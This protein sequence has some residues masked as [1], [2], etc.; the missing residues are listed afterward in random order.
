MADIRE[1]VIEIHIAA[2]AVEENRKLTTNDY[3]A[4]SKA[5]PASF[6]VR[7]KNIEE[8]REKYRK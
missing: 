3:E 4:S 8:E 6:I 1:T 2:F 5:I 7:K